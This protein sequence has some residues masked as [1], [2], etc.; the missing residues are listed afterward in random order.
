MVGRLI[1]TAIRRILDESKLTT[2]SEVLGHGLKT[3]L[4]QSEDSK[5]SEKNRIRGSK[6]YRS[7]RNRVILRLSLLN[8]EGVT[9]HSQITRTF[10]PSFFSNLRFRRSLCTFPRSFGSQ[11]SLLDFGIWESTQPAWWCQKQPLTSIIFL[12]A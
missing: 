7:P 3:R 11:Y 9:S 4:E 2:F 1:R 8:L 12:G 5:R 10:Q 6:L